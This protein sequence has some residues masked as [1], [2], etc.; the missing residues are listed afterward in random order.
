MSSMKNIEATIGQ[1]E[2]L[3]IFCIAGT[4]GL[5]FV[6]CYKTIHDFHD[7]YGKQKEAY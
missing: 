7:A 2:F 3:P 4:K 5:E 6:A 1:H